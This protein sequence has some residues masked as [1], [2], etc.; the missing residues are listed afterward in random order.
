MRPDANV[1][2]RTG[3]LGGI[4]HAMSFDESSVA[5]LMSVLTDLYSDPEL[6]VIREYSTNALDSHIAAGTTR[7]I[8]VSLPN[9]LSPFF[10]VKDYGVGMD[11]DDIQNI[12]SKYGASTKRGTNDQVGM[13]GLGCKSALTYTQQFTLIAIKNGVKY[14]VAI[15]RTEDGSGVMEIV[16][17]SETDE[18]NGVE[19][20]VP[21]NRYHDFGG[22]S[23]NF[24]RFWNS[25]T[26]LVNGKEPE[27]ISGR[28]L[29]DTITVVKGSKID[30]LV[31]GNVGYPLE[32]SNNLFKN[33]SYYS[34]FGIVAKIDIGDVNFTPSRESLHY[35]KKTIATIE[36]IREQVSAG[37]NNAVER[38]I[39]DQESHPAALSTYYEWSQMLGGVNGGA[40]RSV[41]YKGEEIP[42][43]IRGNILQYNRNYSRYAVTACARMSMQELSS[44]PIIHGFDKETLASHYREK[45]RLWASTNASSHARFVIMDSIDDMEWLKWINNDLV[46]HWEDVRKLKVV[47]QRTPRTAVKYDIF[48]GGIWQSLSI[49]EFPT[50][51]G[52][53]LISP[54]NRPSRQFLKSYESVCDTVPIVLLQ[55]ARQAKFIRDNAGS[56]ALSN[57]VRELVQNS[58]DAL[59]DDE[60][61]ILGMD[62]YS[63]SILPH[64]D[65]NK[66]I[67]PSLKFA[68][69][70]AKGLKMT[71]SI[72]RYNST[73][74]LSRDLNVGFKN[75]ITENNP[76]KNYPLLYSL[77][78]DRTYVEHGHIYVNA[79]F[80]A[81]NNKGI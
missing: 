41:K 67:D 65:E 9:G 49:D 4:K 72:K 29:T 77:Q 36:K 52:I 27:Y 62:Y 32:P 75:E 28:K 3:D 58:L 66:V 40:P 57:H 48:T 42:T 10:K 71:D 47:R 20:V 18:P 68:I 61:V 21:V 24:F 1:A 8:E 53:A 79:V 59:T 34:N 26:V 13:L 74:A 7:P 6:A 23:A 56:I 44:N 15:S 16:G 39:N 43:E 54:K 63:R 19:V 81:A 51:T 14:M 69:M 17:E 78:R 22:K 33:R 46:V 11:A 76:L 2:E 35:T 55:D 45:I 25:G 50:H 64:M 60:K 31:M 80:E 5:H 38:D 30:Y 12:Y 73:S 37:F 70:A